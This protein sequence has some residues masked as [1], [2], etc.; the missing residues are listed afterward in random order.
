MGVH[1]VASDGR[2]LSTYGP[3][4]KAG[5]VITESFACRVCNSQF[6]THKL[7]APV[8][9]DRGQPAFDISQ[10]EILCHKVAP[11]ILF[12]SWDQV[13]LEGAYGA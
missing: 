12:T 13:V 11:P 5:D 9:T 10:S 6:T 3:D 4:A 1:F 7:A 2:S 8:G